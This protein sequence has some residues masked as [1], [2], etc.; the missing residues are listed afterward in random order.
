M[1]SPFIPNNTWRATLDLNDDARLRMYVNV[2][3]AD[4]LFVQGGKDI[5]KLIYNLHMI[6]ADISSYNY[7]YNHVFAIV[8]T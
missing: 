6:D 5:A 1:S 3:H 7:A 8:H 4:I 2:V